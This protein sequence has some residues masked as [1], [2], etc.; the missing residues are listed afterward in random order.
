MT[1]HLGKVPA[2]TIGDVHELCDNGGKTPDNQMDLYN[3]DQGRTFGE[4]A[5]VEKDCERSCVK[6]AKDGT[7]MIKLPETDNSI[8]LDIPDY[9]EQDEEYY[10]D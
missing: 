1:L 6:A 10:E 3:N 5:T 9:Y 8:E 7:L 4:T 2:K